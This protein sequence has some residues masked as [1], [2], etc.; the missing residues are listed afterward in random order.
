[1]HRVEH[2]IKTISH[3]LVNVDQQTVDLVP[4]VWLLVTLLTLILSLK[5]FNIF[6][7]VCKVALKSR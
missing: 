2:F 3:C 1:M 7:T 4:M 6:S 5:S